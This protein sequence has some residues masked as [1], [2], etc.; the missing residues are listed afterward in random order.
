MRSPSPPFSACE[1]SDAKTLSNYPTLDDSVRSALILPPPGHW[2]RGSLGSAEGSSDSE[3]EHPLPRRRKLRHRLRSPSP[4]SRPPR[5]SVRRRPT[6][7][8]CST[9]ADDGMANLGGNYD[10]TVTD[11]AAGDNGGMNLEQRLD[12]AALTLGRHGGNDML[13]SAIGSNGGHPY[14]GPGFVHLGGGNGH[15]KQQI[16]PNSQLVA[17]VNQRIYGGQNGPLNLNPLQGRS[18]HE[19]LG[20]QLGFRHNSETEAFQTPHNPPQGA[21]YG[22]APTAPPIGGNGPALFVPTPGGVAPGP[23]APGGAPATPD[24]DPLQALA[25]TLQANL[26]QSIQA[27]IQQYMQ[28]QGAPTPPP[29]PIRP[30]AHYCALPGLAPPVPQAPPPGLGHMMGGIPPPAFAPPRLIMRRCPPATLPPM[31]GPRL[32]RPRPLRPLSPHRFRL[33]PASNARSPG[34]TRAPSEYVF[35]PFYPGSAPQAPAY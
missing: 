34:S 35:G 20:P 28:A 7:P 11:D 5:P 16:V 17:E 6:F 1:L 32:L 10:G 30:E 19:R 31:L 8:R 18:V 22:H 33:Q 24:P 13:S 14:Y 15:P 3:D 27:G 21:G 2:T 29:D 4:S 12:D 25:A 9:R 23:Q 26:A